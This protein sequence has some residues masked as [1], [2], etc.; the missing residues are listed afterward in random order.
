MNQSQFH[1]PPPGVPYTR[2]EAIKRAGAGFGLLALASLLRDQG[3][4]VGS[5]SAAE[6]DSTNPLAPRQ[7]HFPAKAKS[8]IWLF[9]NG[10][11]SQVD[12]WDYK[13]ELEKRDGVKLANFD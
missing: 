8:L 2:R 12:T 13:P 5:A 3:L 7:P 6:L 9:I 4:L 11:P 10:G 1:F